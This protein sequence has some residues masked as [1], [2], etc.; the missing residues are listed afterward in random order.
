MIHYVWLGGGTK[1]ETIEKCLRSW[2]EILPEYKIYCWDENTF[3]MESAP[4]FFKEA[5]A[6]KKWAF[7]SDYIRLWALNKYGGIYFDTD[8]EV[9]KSLDVFLEHRL[10][11]GI[12]VF[13]VDINKHR[14]ELRTNLSIG[15]IG[16]VAGHPYIQQCIDLYRNAHFLTETGEIDTT[17]SNYKMAEILSGF[18]YK[19]EDREQHLQEGI[20]VYPSSVF[21][22]RLYPDNSKD[23]YTFHWGEMSWFEPNKRGWLHNLC[24]KLNLMWL[25]RLI[26]RIRGTRK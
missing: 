8:V 20:V 4:A 15:V 21:S 25:Y 18:G 3:D 6:A 1:S 2:S 24:W 11:I 13:P 19:N 14:R 12:Q 16:A 22:D 9:R 10:F 5:Y 17:V 23:C 7:A 26:E